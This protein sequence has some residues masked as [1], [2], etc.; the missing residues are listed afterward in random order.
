[1]SNLFRKKVSPPE[2]MSPK[3]I[4]VWGTHGAPGRTTIAI[5]L[6]CELALNGA[7]VLL[8]DLDSQAP[9]IADCFGLLDEKPGVAAAFRLV[10][11]GRLDLAQIERLSTSYDVAGGRLSV[12]TGLRAANRWPELTREKTQSLI[13]IAKQH[14]D[15]VIMDVSADLEVGIRQIGGV[16]DRNCTSRTA[17]EVADQA[18]AVFSADPIGVRRLVDSFQSLSELFAKPILVANRLRASS[19]GPSA[20]QQIEDAIMQLCRLEVAAFVALDIDSCDKAIMQSVPLAMMKR[21]SKARQAIA[22]LARLNFGTES[23]GWRG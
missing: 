18:I 8:I 19:L 13:T 5:N 21:T 22:Q 6:A 23:Q 9:S 11:Q 17:L 2:S 3:A 14:F 15:F 12:M 7:K 20:R 1:M 10:G 16:V 4:C